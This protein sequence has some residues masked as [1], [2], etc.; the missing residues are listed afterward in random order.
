M[1][2]EG[3]PPGLPTPEAVL[4]RIGR[5]NFQVASRILPAAA[6][7]HLLAFYGFARL[8]DQ[9]GDAYDGDRM[10]A[11]EWL[12][13]DTRAALAG[14]PAHPLV[15]PAARSVSDLGID[16][17]PLFDLIEANR[18]DQEVRRYSSFE[19]LVGYC[20]LSANPIGRLVLGAFGAAND[21]TIAL[22][23]C[24]CTGL[25]LV[26]HWQDVK[27]DAVAGRVYL[28]GDDLD[29]FG[30]DP[31]TL[32]GTSPA[33]QALRALMAFETARARTWLDR[34][35]P[36]VQELDGRA[37]WA[38]AGFVAGGRA[39][40]DAIAARDFDVL[41][42]PTRPRPWTVAR[43]ALVLTLNRHGERA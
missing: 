16:S 41:S 5:E 6:R 18:R 34:G 25:Q 21:R 33:P 27:E 28:P 7:R 17:Q 9:I 2:G 31:A 35:R 26:E 29:R 11:L 39:A 8:T 19:E 14:E 22:S 15:A 3:P 20:E 40:L 4:G 38:V 32:A 30:I 24:V 36:L 23:D 13:A 1:T 37:R 12:E 10:A 42:P 43:Y